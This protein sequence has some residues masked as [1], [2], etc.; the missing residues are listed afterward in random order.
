[1]K[2]G[3]DICL[4]PAI[5]PDNRAAGDGESTKWEG[6][7]ILEFEEPTERFAE[8]SST[9]V[10]AVALAETVLGSE[11]V[12][13]SVPATNAASVNS[14]VSSSEGGGNSSPLP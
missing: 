12:N 6:N 11:A 9:V 2:L 13:G 4:V 14:A 10:A 1:M 3:V 8:K 5:E 7:D